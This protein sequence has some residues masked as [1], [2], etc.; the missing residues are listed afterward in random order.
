MKKIAFL[1]VFL[2]IVQPVWAQKIANKYK[3]PM[4]NILKEELGKLLKDME[5]QMA[6]SD[7]IIK[8]LKVPT[9]LSPYILNDGKLLINKSIAVPANL[10]K[11]LKGSVRISK[12]SF[13][14]NEIIP[15]SL[16]KK[17]ASKLD[18][19]GKTEVLKLSG[20]LNFASLNYKAKT[21]RSMPN[22]NPLAPELHKYL[23]G[24]FSNYFGKAGLPIT[25]NNYEMGYSNGFKSLIIRNLNLN[26]VS[27]KS[28]YS[29]KL[30]VNLEI[31]L[32]LVS[33]ALKYD[34]TIDAKSLQ[35]FV[36]LT[37]GQE[38]PYLASSKKFK[39]PLL[40]SEP[41]QIKVKTKEEGYS[42]DLQSIVKKNKSWSAV[43]DFKKSTEN[44]LKNENKQPVTDEISN[45]N[46]QA[47][48]NLKK[49]KKALQKY[50]SEKI[51]SFLKQNLSSKIEIRGKSPRIFITPD[52]ENV[53]I[54]NAYIRPDVDNLH[55]TKQDIPIDL[56]L[57]PTE[58]LPFATYLNAFPK[59]SKFTE[60][61]KKQLNMQTIF[62]SKKP[63][64][65]LSGRATLAQ[66]KASFRKG[67]AAYFTQMKLPFENAYYDLNS[68]FSSDKIFVSELIIKYFRLKYIELDLMTNEVKFSQNKVERRQADKTDAEVVFI[69]SEIKKQL[70]AKFSEEMTYHA[71][72]DKLTYPSILIDKA[73]IINE[74]KLIQDAKYLD[75]EVGRN[76]FIAKFSVKKEMEIRFFDKKSNKELTDLKQV[77][78]QIA[79]QT[80][81]FD[82]LVNN[83]A[84][85]S[86]VQNPKVSYQLNVAHADYKNASLSIDYQDFKSGKKIFLSKRSLSC[87]FDFTFA[88]AYETD[89]LPVSRE[90]DITELPRTVEFPEFSGKWNIKNPT[91]LQL[92]T[93]DFKNGQSI[94]RSIKL[95]RIC[96][97]TQINLS[98]D[99]IPAGL[100]VYYSV[101]AFVK[102]E[103]KN[104]KRFKNKMVQITASIPVKGTA[105]EGV[106]VLVNKPF[107][108]NIFPLGNDSLSNWTAKDFLVKVTNKERVEQKMKLCKLKKFSFFYLDVSEVSDKRKLLMFVDAELKK[109][110]EA[111]D[112]YFMFLSNGSKSET[113]EK[114]RDYLQI[115]RKIPV[116][117]T[118]PPIAVADVKKLTSVLPVQNIQPARTLTSMNFFLSKT[119]YKHS[120]N[121]LIS[122]FLKKIAP[123]RKL[124]G[125]IINIFLDYDVDKEDKFPN[126]DDIK[127]NYFNINTVNEK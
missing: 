105:E 115:L 108:Y 64:A 61:E 116:L 45:A 76:A 49:Y 118:E 48:T 65:S 109:I 6:K 86:L 82:K 77:K 21:E 25:D 51:V 3:T 23:Q 106:Q 60:Q 22:L 89:Q 32:L 2:L 52:G 68:S 8:K 83:L 44:T 126:S 15:A 103:S 59:I 80:S 78:L 37:H 12:L 74:L 14:E 30:R 41:E 43:I 113:A 53:A 104:K 1:I 26:I 66:Y 121:Y 31:P 100:K 71:D 17:M 112:S 98:F 18:K 127:Y 102:T 40:F 91:F 72:K 93:A 50:F 67:I 84:K 20:K 9:A 90:V 99:A 79:Y 69:F 39:Y 5:R 58:K 122:D 97:S 47:S 54:E 70:A 34:G 73:L 10:N 114:G 63:S 46:L 36:L 110:N 33:V 24:L 94:R 117:N 57:F 120:R 19:A 29:N 96:K 81:S 62:S 42:V 101:R 125:L 11:Y 35:Q 123:D 107:G 85:L 92:K 88:K 38:I 28:P 95:E 13:F 111:A 87:A 75:S 16:L 119:I 7:K 55:F 124:N 27:L 56:L 4:K